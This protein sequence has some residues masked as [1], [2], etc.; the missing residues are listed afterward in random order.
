MVQFKVKQQLADKHPRPVLGRDHIRV[1]PEPTQ[2]RAH[3]PGFIHRRLDVDAD[4]SFG[5]RFLLSDPR[6]QRR[7][8]LFDYVVVII[9]PR[10]AGDFPCRWTL[11]VLMR[12]EVV[13]S[14]DYD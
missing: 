1:F 4:L 2:T 12:R 14:D 7:K 3:G 6:K 11:L 5:S 10:V 9:S 13:E 8:F